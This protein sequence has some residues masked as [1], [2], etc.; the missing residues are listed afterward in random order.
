[1]AC[2]FVKR[3]CARRPRGSV[4]KVLYD[5]KEERHRARFGAFI[6]RLLL[7]YSRG[8]YS[9]GNS[10][11]GQALAVAAKEV[12]IRNQ[13]LGLMYQP[14]QPTPES[15]LTTH[16]IHLEGT[17]EANKDNIAQMFRITELYGLGRT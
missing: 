11:A 8:V 6:W 17:C 9:Q 15:F 4:D 14:D 2:G 13:E 12:D 5:R 3:S 10:V 16:K 7:A 1:M